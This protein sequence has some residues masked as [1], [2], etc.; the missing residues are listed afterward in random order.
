MNWARALF[1]WQVVG[2]VVFIV[3]WFAIGAAMYAGN[4]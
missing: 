4:Q 1:F 3:F 2:I